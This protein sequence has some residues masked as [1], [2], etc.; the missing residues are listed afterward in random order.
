M[1]RRRLVRQIAR[2][3]KPRRR[4]T[5]AK[6]SV[7]LRLSR[8]VTS[9]GPAVSSGATSVDQPPAL[10]RIEQPGAAQFGKRSRG[11]RSGPIEEAGVGHRR[12][13]LYGR[14][15]AMA[16]SSW[17]RLSSARGCASALAG[18]SAAKLT[19]RVG[20]CSS[21]FVQHLVG[22]IET[23]VE[24]H[25]LAA[26][27]HQIGFPLLGDFGDDL[28]H[29]ALDAF[30]RL[31]I[32][33]FQRLAF[34]LHA[35]VELVDLLLE[36]A[37]LLVQ[38]FGRQRACCRCNASRSLPQRFF[39]LRDLLG[40]FA[41]LLLDL[42]SHHLCRFRVLQ[43][44]LNVDDQHVQGRRRRRAWRGRRLLRLGIAERRSRP[45]QAR[46]AGRQPARITDIRTS[47]QN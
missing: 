28:Q 46:P 15:A 41:A 8:K 34:G 22:H 14:R 11:V 38:R 20:S 24:Q 29:H 7:Y 17:R 19:V 21:S 35:A 18:V 43:Q 33:V 1:P 10:G 44:R 30:E 31:G 36:F 12:W 13:L 9:S 32:G 47:Y 39:L 5:R 26:L 23:L 42:L 4:A 2:R 40:V 45:E 37:A 25:Q 27:E 3:R 6:A 16:F